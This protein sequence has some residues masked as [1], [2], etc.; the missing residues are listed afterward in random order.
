MCVNKHGWRRGI[1]DFVERKA[2]GVFFAAKLKH[3][4]VDIP[5]GYPILGSIM[6]KQPPAKQPPAFGRSWWYLEKVD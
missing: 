6:A 3:S 2:C 1:K 5:S 4:P